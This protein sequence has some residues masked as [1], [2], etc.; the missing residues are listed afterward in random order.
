MKRT[1]SVIV[2][3]FIAVTL[4][5]QWLVP[6]GLAYHYTDTTNHW[7]SA[8]IDKVTNAGAYAASGNYFCPNTNEKRI[9]FVL[10]LALL[11][12]EMYF[13]YNNQNTQ[14]YSDVPAGSLNAG[15]VLWAK[16]NGITQGIEP[17]VF[18][19]NL[20]ISREQL[21]TFIYRACNQFEFN[22]HFTT[23]AIT[24]SDSGNISD[25]A[26]PAVTALQ[27]AEIINGYPDGTFK[28][29]KSV[30]R[31]EVST[32]L[33]RLMENCLDV[34]KDAPTKTGTWWIGVVENSWTR[35]DYTIDYQENGAITDG[36]QI[37][38]Y[39][40]RA[41][42]ITDIGVTNRGIRAGFLS[43]IAVSSYIEGANY[44]QS[45]YMTENPNVPVSGNNDSEQH[46]ASFVN[47]IVNLNNSIIAKIGYAIDAEGAVN[48]FTT[49]I[50]VSLSN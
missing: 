43:P 48:P 26:R 12:G 40:R 42:Q 35:C 47:K 31:A 7:A 50:S 13:I 39:Y 14:V 24:F 17:G 20:N 33:S 23:T 15:A 2:A 44:L 37:R 32:I 36:H 25:W 11:L 22:L 46:Y 6:N 1:K 45:F 4:F 5:F 34:T 41:D 49:T 21:C 38:Y 28:P 30:T 9:D 10:N 8:Y 18:G 27:K 29:K 16:N 19:P 3:A